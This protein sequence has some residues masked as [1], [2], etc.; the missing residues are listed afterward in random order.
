MDTSSCEF[1]NAPP[2]D[3]RKVWD[4][5]QSGD[6]C[7]IEFVVEPFMSMTYHKLM[8]KRE[9]VGYRAY[10]NSISALALYRE[11]DLEL[12]VD[13]Q[14]LDQPITT[15][16]SFRP[17][18]TVNGQM[19]GPTIIT[20]ENQMLNVTVYNELPNAEGISIHWHGMHQ[21][22]T[23]E[24]DGVAFITQYPILP[25]Q[26]YTY[27]FRASPAGTHWYHAHSG[28]HR[29]DGLYGALIVKDTIPGFGI[30]IKDYPERH[31]LLLMDWQEEPSIDLFYQIRSS[32]SFWDD[33]RRKFMDT[34]GVD[35]TQIA[36]IPFWSG[37]I[38]DKGRHFNKTGAPNY[39]DLN[40]FYVRQGFQYRFRLIGAQ[41]LYAYKF[42]IESHTLTVVA[43]DGNRIDSIRDVHYVIVNTGERYDVIVNAN[44]TPRRYWILAETLE[45]ENN[46]DPFHNPIESHKAEA[47]LQYEGGS[48]FRYSESYTWTCT[49]N[50]KCRF[51]NCPYLPSQLAN[52]VCINVD[53][54]S[55]PGDYQTDSSI[56]RPSKTLFY[57]FGFDGEKSTRGSSVDGINFRF[58]SHLP[59]TKEFIDDNQY[60]P[61][62]GCDHDADGIDHCTCTQVI[63][64]DDVR[65]G[66]IVELV[67]TN[68]PS[69]NFVGNAE[70]AHPV[71]LHG[72]S[73]YVV[74]LGYPQYH[75]NGIYSS[76]NQDVECIKHTGGECDR[77]ITVD[78]RSAGQSTRVQTV[79]WTNN[80][81]PSDIIF[82]NPSRRYVKKDTVIVPYGGYAVIRFTVDNP[83]WWFLHCHI[84]IHQLEGM[85][86]VIK[87][88]THVQSAGNTHNCACVL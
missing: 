14:T 31:T 8:G 87:E 27:E 61:G 19:P 4:C 22:D 40:I 80:T 46:E 48:T 78:R 83:G 73:F 56:Y 65:K 29:T 7:N 15:D 34:K 39:A 49:V 42:S 11:N 85:S 55:S 35:N 16:G 79:G 3:T 12:D 21:K 17:I 1:N 25:Y 44:Q 24:M 23:P 6:I 5:L 75:P 71:H 54:F 38:N 13:T 70:S 52:H 45:V 60:C 47:F 57:N 66:Q 86:A 63:D 64:I 50:N 9:L 20:R 10:F 84:E 32:L 43:T 30:E 68:R 36:P 72:H 74:K 69:N 76:P 37:I 2:I 33:A 18:I 82:S 26:S 51:V 77:F 58:P 67:I 41:A 28:A 53:Q 81:P 62:R 88:L 59:G